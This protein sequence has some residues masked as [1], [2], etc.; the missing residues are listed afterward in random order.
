MKVKQTELC[1]ELQG[2][3]LNYAEEVIKNR[4]IPDIRDGLKPVHRRILWSMWSMGCKP[5]ESMKKCARVV[6]DCFKYHP[7]GDVAIYEALVRMA[8]PFAIGTP[9]IKGQGNFG[10]VDDSG[11]YASFRY[12]ECKLSEFADQLFFADI[13]Y[14]AIDF[15]D[16]YTGEFKEPSVLPARLPVILLT[17]SNGIAVGMKT[18]ILPHNLREVCAGLIAYIGNENITLKELMKIIPAPDFPLGGKIKRTAAIT[19]A[20]DG[21]NGMIEYRATAK[22]EDRSIVFSTIPYA[23]SKCDVIAQL[24]QLVRD[25]KIL[26]VSEVRDE[27]AKSEIRVCI[28]V[29]RGFAPE[30]VLTNIY[31]YS[32]LSKNFSINSI[33]ISEAKPKLVGLLSILKSFVAFRRE[34]VRRRTDNQRLKAE[35]RKEIVDAIIIAVHHAELVLKIIRTADEPVVELQSKLKLNQ[36][37]AE[38]IYNMPMRKF[39]KIDVGELS[40]EEVEVS[41]F[42]K[43]QKDILADKS[44]IDQIIIDETNELSKT[45]GCDRHTGVVGEFR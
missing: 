32:D 15:V 23:Q 39:S 7:H 42:V 30:D 19:G 35:R 28:D 20:Y 24:S 9:F 2:N 45:F 5:K 16:N 14:D 21:G 44:K 37:Q 34:T 38:Y 29:K 6:G 18:D 4:A 33:A 10:S 3:F 36:T 25:E 43:K 8:Q 1:A 13:D 41:A 31:K 40:A 27:S 22:I 12:T 26:G 17:G 11:A